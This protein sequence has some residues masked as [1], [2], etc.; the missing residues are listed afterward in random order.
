M[1][2]TASL[3]RPSPRITENRVGYY[4]N[5]TKVTAAIISELQ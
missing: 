3:N 2:A 4:S 1:M 5:L